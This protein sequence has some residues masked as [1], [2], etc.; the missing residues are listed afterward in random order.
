MNL[1]LQSFL[2]Y[3]G[4]KIFLKERTKEKKYLKF[5]TEV[6]IKKTIEYIDRRNFERLQTNYEMVYNI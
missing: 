1:N 3:V 2:V 6:G 5:R 4:I